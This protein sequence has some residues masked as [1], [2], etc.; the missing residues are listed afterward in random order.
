MNVWGT[1]ISIFFK[2]L[3]QLL[4]PSVNKPNKSRIEELIDTLNRVGQI[5]SKVKKIKHTK[6]DPFGWG[7]PSDLENEAFWGEEGFWGDSNRKK[8]KKLKNSPST[9]K[10]NNEITKKTDFSRKSK[11]ATVRAGEN[12]NDQ[13]DSLSRD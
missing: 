3:D 13:K 12:S 8:I 11:Y 4:E 10:P 1:L 2:I 5:E 6:K 9:N 7:D